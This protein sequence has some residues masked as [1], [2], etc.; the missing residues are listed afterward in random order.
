MPTK[1][2]FERQPDAK[3]L[4]PHLR[5][6]AASKWPMVEKNSHAGQNAVICSTGKSIKDKAV[7]KKVK[8]LAKKGYVVFGLKETIP[9]L[10]D[11]GV[12][13]TYSVSMDPG[14]ERQINRT[15]F[16]KDVT[17]CLASSCHPDLYDYLGMKGGKIMIFHSACGH[18]EEGYKPGMFVQAGPTDFAICPGVHTM[19]TLEGENEFTPIV[20]LVKSE[21][22]IYDEMFPNADVMCGGFT[23][24]NRALAL[25]K[26]MG[27]DKV[28]L[29]G[30][31]FGWREKGKS[32]YSDLVSV[33]TLDSSY[34]T[35]NAQVDGREWFTKPDQLAS[36][37]DIAHKQKAGEIEVLGDS[38]AAALAKRDDAFLDEIVKIT[39]R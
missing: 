6:S 13:V 5:H 32:H 27:F 34:M 36:A 26:F 14:G 39:T 24:S 22:Q 31:D 1:I 10:K 2:N 37:V 20:Q 15:P 28:V 38:L 4:G 11:H 17:Y 19:K 29:A 33:D 7:L 16:D 21:V 30:T 8:R 9:Y 3:D 25:A 23:V 12:K 35:D 18:S